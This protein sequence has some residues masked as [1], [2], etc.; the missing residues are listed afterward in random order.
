MSLL[1]AG[2]VVL[3][4]ASLS[5]WLGCDEC[6]DEVQIVDVGSEFLDRGNY[7]FHFPGG[8]LPAG[9]RHAGTT[10]DDSY[11]TDFSYTIDVSTANTATSERDCLT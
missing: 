8:A 1:L 7:A 3:L 5:L 2:F 10:L 6:G 11:S 4:L 9:E